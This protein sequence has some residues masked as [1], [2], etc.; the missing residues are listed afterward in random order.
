M[1]PTVLTLSGIE[2][3]WN[4]HGRSLF[5]DVL[6]PEGIDRET[7]TAFIISRAG[8]F[9]VVDF[10][11]DY[12]LKKTELWFK[13]NYDDFDR[14]LKVFTAEY[15]PL[16]DYYRQ[17]DEAHND[18][19]AG[20]VNVDNTITG[21]STTNSNSSGSENV[22]DKTSAYN[23][24]TYSPEHK[25]DSSNSNTTGT[26]GSNTSK[27]SGSNYDTR[28]SNGEYHKTIKGRNAKAQE[29]IKD[30]LELRESY[31]IYD[32]ISTLYIREFCLPIYG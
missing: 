30:E 20:V 12:M 15:D 25:T 27:S 2:S 3:Y 19:A 32:M 10:D 13:A 11:P 22:E 21:S 18:H 7:M 17:E 5:G 26:T 6:I 1:F 28:N 8:D 16:N 23:S 31:N 24:A 4:E 29:L 9:S 14:W